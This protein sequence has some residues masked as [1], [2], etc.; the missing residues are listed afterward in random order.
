MSYAQPGIKLGNVLSGSGWSEPPPALAFAAMTVLS[1]AN[2]PS[3][4]ILI[5]IVSP[6]QNEEG[7]G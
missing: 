1:R 4:S 7:F 3:E 5:F 6:T 2:N